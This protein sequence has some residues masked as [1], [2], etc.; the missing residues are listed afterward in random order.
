MKLIKNINNKYL[1]YLIRKSMDPKEK[2]PAN[3]IRV[4]YR[5]RVSN[6]VSYAEKLLK[7]NNVKT[8]NFSAVGGSIGTLVNVV[9]ILKLNTP[10]L[11]QQN[12]IATIAYQ[13]V[14]DKNV[15]RQRLYPKFET[16]LSVEKP[17][18]EGEGYQAPL[19]EEERKKIQEIK[20]KGR[21]LRRR[22][23]FRGG[24]GS[25]GRGR[26]FGRGRRGY[27]RPRGMRGGFRPRGMR[28]GFRGSR[29]MRGRGGP[30]RRGMRG[31]GPMRRGRGM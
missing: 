5:T 29:G 4:G 16:I 8:L 9:E 21:E 23:G 18:K 27:G 30:M 19:T 25:R 15:E 6:V 17:A 26:N 14:E 7:E 31:S 24:R 10:G 13:S 3:E 12:R 1:K 2:K 22:G 20:E 28:G 11:Y